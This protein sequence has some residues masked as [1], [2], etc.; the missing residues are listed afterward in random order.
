MDF[1]WNDQFSPQIYT[2]FDLPTG[3]LVP[4]RKFTENGQN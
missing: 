4:D 2:V 1:R 3:Y